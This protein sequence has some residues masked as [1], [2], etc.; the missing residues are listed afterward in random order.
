ME[1][2]VRSCGDR[3]KRM[4]RYQM[5][6]EQRTWKT[7]VKQDMEDWCDEATAELLADTEDNAEILANSKRLI[8]LWSRPEQLRDSIR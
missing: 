5:P 6:T 3:I 2:H 7:N 4:A 8:V 1:D